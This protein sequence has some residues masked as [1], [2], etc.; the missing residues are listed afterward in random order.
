[1]G[2]NRVK[3]IVG[4][5]GL[6]YYK[7]VESY[8]KYIDLRYIPELFMIRRDDFGINIGVA[9]TISKAIE[10][11]K[12]CNQHGFHTEE[13][14]VYKK[15]ADHMEKVVSGFIRNSASLGGNL[16]MA[17]RNHF[18]SDIATVLLA[19]GSLVNIM[20]GLKSV[21]LTME[22]FLRRSELDSKSILLSVKILDWNRLMGIS[23]GTRMNLLVGTYRA[24]HDP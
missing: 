7:K 5:T 8:D 21:E 1:M 15:I 18:S 3:V 13:N 9:V 4:N 12:E 16:V 24:A 6:G 10:A 11:V 14:M 19:V 17:Q 23:S 2:V 22:E 20:N